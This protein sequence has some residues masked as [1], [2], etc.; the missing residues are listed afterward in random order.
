MHI[1]SIG[2]DYGWGVIRSSTTTRGT[3]TQLRRIVIGRRHSNHGLAPVLH[4]R[5]QL[6]VSSY[7][8][9]SRRRLPA[10]LGR[11]V[12]HDYGGRGHGPG[13]RTSRCRF[14]RRPGQLG[15]ISS[16]YGSWVNQKRGLLRV[17]VVKLQRLRMLLN[18]ERACRRGR[19]HRLH[20][21]RT[22]DHRGACYLVGQQ[23]LNQT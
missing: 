4:W 1:H 17:L 20:W 19:R 9:T 11:N 2:C 3:Q 15:L 8:H 14:A 22:H 23:T 16:T 12:R 6:I 7:R 18:V 21:R 5:L 13:R 10:A